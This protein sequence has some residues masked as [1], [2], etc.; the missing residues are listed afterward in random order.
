MNV[1]LLLKDALRD[2]NAAEQE[3]TSDGRI[4]VNNKGSRKDYTKASIW[5]DGFHNYCVILTILHADCEPRLYQEL[6]RLQFKARNWFEQY[7]LNAVMNWVL[8]IH[9]AA[10]LAGP[11]PVN[12]WRWTASDEIEYVNI[13]SHKT[14]FSL[15]SGTSNT[16]AQRRN[17]QNDG[18]CNNYNYTQYSVKSCQYEHKCNVCGKG[19]ARKDNIACRITKD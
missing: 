5:L 16:K 9:N 15:S 19:Y 3:I 14:S 18:S 13:G 17:R 7:E 12:S 11:K 1:S 6:S 10:L 8:S 2:P 4:K